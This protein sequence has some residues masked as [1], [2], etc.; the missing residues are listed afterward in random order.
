[1]PPPS[2]V[3]NQRY[4]PI[5]DKYIITGKTYTTASGT[6]IPNELQYYNGEM[7]HFYGECTNVTAVNEALADTGYKALTLKYADGRETAVAQLWSSRFTDTS[8]GPYGAMFIVIVVVRN[9]AAPR[10][11]IDQGGPQWRIERAGDARR[12]VRRCNSGV[13]EQG[14]VVPGPPSRHNSGR[15]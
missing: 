3:V 11:G 6:V 12:I 7:V 9:D 5:F 15:H 8:I 10:P 13:R 14:T 1:M 4:E 2:D